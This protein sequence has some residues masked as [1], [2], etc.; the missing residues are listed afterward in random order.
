MAKFLVKNK[1]TYDR[2]PQTDFS[3]CVN[4]GPFSKSMRGICSHNYVPDLFR[5]DG[6]GNIGVFGFS[7]ERPVTVV[8]P[9]ETKA[10]LKDVT[11]IRLSDA[12]A[13]AGTVLRAVF[14]GKKGESFASACEAGFAAGKGICFSLGKMDFEPEKLVLETNGG[15]VSCRIDLVYVKNTL[16]EFPGQHHFYSVS[17]GATLGGRGGSMVLGLDGKGYFEAK[18]LPLDQ[19][20]AYGMKMPLRNTVFAVIRNL[21]GAKTATIEF[22][23]ETAPEYAG[24]NSVELELAKDKEPHAYY[25][26]L[27]ACPGCDGRLTGFRLGS[28]G[29]GELVI[30]SYSFEQEKPFYDVY[31]KAESC[32]ADP[33]KDVFS[34]SGK[35]A[36]DAGKGLVKDLAETFIGGKIEVYAGT[37]ADDTGF[38]TASETVAGKKYLAGIPFPENAAPG[39]SFEIRDIP[40]RDDKTTMLP[41]QLL[42]FARSED[43]SK[44]RCLTDRFYIENYECFDKSPYSFELPSFAVK[45]TDFGAKGDAVS[46]DTEAIQK[47]IDHV[48]KK[49]GG[50]VVVPGDGSFYG[51]RYIVTSILLRSNVELSIETGAV[52]WQSQRR[53]HYTY[54]PAYG[55]DDIIPGI[56]WTHNLHT[57]NLPLIQG[58]NLENIKITGGG[59]IRMLDTGSEENVGMPGYSVGCHRR[60]HCIPLG[61]FICKNVEVR[62]I[63]IQRSNN[64]HTSFNHCENVYIANV[65]LHRVKCVSGDG[66][67]V[68][69]VKN[70]LV[71]RCFFQS[72]DD[73]I[74]M[75]THYEDPRGLLWWTNT[76]DEDNSVRFVTVKHCYLNSGG[77]KAIC[78]I[79][80]GTSDPDQEREEISNVVAEDNVL[81]CVNPVGA[82]FDNPYNG[83][84][85]F[86]N[87]ETDDYSPVK[88]IRIFNNRYEGI[89]SLGPIQ[90]TDILTDC[91]I[92][93]ASDFRNGDF[94]LGGL[95]NWTVNRNSDPESA[96]TAVYCDKT[97]GM[98]E[99]FDEGDVSCLQGLHLCAGLHKFSCETLT[100]PSGAKLVAKVI[101]TG[102]VIA[103]KTVVSEY[104]RFE[105]ISFETSEDLDVYVGIASNGDSHDGFCVFDH[106]RM[107]SVT[108]EE[109]RKRSLEKK[110]R[111]K[112]EKKFTIPECFFTKAE[113][114][115]VNLCCESLGSEKAVTANLP[116]K[117]FAIEAAI[118]IDA[119]PEKGAGG[120][121]FR[122]GEKNGRYRELRVNI[123]GRTLV[124]KEVYGAIEKELFRK[125]DFFF[126]SLD[127]HNYRLEVSENTAT[128]RIDSG[129]YTSVTTTVPEGTVSLRIFNINASVNGLDIE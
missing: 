80:W 96:H 112:L 108:D 20:N 41:Y 90:A 129:L 63:S 78:F 16:G 102:E 55:H 115:K 116:K 42:L 111:E 91:G 86:D 95:A 104:P 50:K 121:A 7:K 27:S 123:T 43:G 56:N 124:I 100:G 30:D 64:Y 31:C 11:G 113:E 99:H 21:C 69:G 36:E 101:Q 33:E 18:D 81:T 73:A 103:E 23:S 1:Y 72:N 68:C 82:W 106:C 2:R 32:V 107:E 46:D 14:F 128:L 94:S 58:A 8:L 45:V 12:T 109:G 40:L 83:K 71:N 84:Q 37:M 47:A 44:T 67:G 122:F 126:T 93:S 105:E 29:R 62:D 9:D 70:A 17:E 75:S 35:F 57:A 10:L 24:E 54:E 120:Y 48:A 77:G 125:D 49:G 22:T 118:R 26:N 34:I 59:V 74:V 127:F 19:G 88:Q 92:V 52:L 65:K 53:E 98:I 89:C 61:L 114:G 51:R 85:P 119:L 25:F 38:G 15:E 60:I 3:Y 110:L 6:A 97:K 5:A 117:N 28:E 4:Y 39:E 76:R 79:T 66:F 13:E 87:T